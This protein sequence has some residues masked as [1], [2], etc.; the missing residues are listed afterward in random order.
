M[1]R[2]AH[3]VVRRGTKGETQ[4]QV[5]GQAI[6][7]GRQATSHRTVHFDLEGEVR[8]APAAAGQLGNR[9]HLAA[10]RERCF[11]SVQGS[12][13]RLCSIPRLVR[14]GRAAPAV[15]PDDGAAEVPQPAAGQPGRPLDRR[16]VQRRPLPG[17]PRRR[18]AD[19]PRSG[20]PLHQR[21]GQEIHRPGHLP[22]PPAR[23]RAG[24]GRR[25]APAHHG[26]GRTIGIAPEVVSGGSAAPRLPMGPRTGRP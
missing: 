14:L 8:I 19:R 10:R 7:T 4:Q 26:D 17:D 24:G 13:V 3:A 20:Q 1:G 2:R 22:V 12:T 15:Q 18:R 25:S 11:R 23:R 6:L 16:P 9:P 21:D 5:T